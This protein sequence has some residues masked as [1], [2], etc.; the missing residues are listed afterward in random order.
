[1][2]LDGELTT[3]ERRIIDL[4]AGWQRVRVV[5]DHGWPSCR[6]VWSRPNLPARAMKKGRGI[7]ARSVSMRGSGIEPSGTTRITCFEAGSDHG[8]LN[9][10]EVVVPDIVVT[11][12]AWSRNLVQT[13]EDSAAI[14]RSRAQD[15]PLNW[16]SPRRSQCRYGRKPRS[17]ER[18]DCCPGRQPEGT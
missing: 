6:A 12:I 1:M 18:L 9:P 11:A 3:I 5:T 13:R 15:I 16:Q 2:I 4:D 17:R 10:P 8:G 14:S 7:P